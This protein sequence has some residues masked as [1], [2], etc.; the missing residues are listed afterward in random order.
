M[1]LE[2][3]LCMIPLML[4]GSDGCHKCIL[5]HLCVRMCVFVYTGMSVLILVTFHVQGQVVGA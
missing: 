2:L 3:Y 4:L 1:T 5:L